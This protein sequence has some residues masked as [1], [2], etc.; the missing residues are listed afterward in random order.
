MAT[1]IL[2]N[3]KEAKKGNP[4]A[5][6]RNA[7]TY[8]MNPEKTENGL[9]VTGN[10]GI[11][12]DEIYNAMMET[13]NVFQKKWGRQ[14]YHF[15]ISFPPGETDE[16]TCFSIGKEFCENY[17]GDRYEYVMAVHNDHEHMH[18]HI[19]FN[20]VGRLDGSKYRYVDGDW[21]KYIQPLTDS[22]AL[23]HGLSKL[24][25]EKGRKK[26]TSYAEHAAEKSGKFT[27][28]KIIRLDIDM[29]VSNSETLE[30]YFSEMKRMGYEIRIG[31]S[32]KY[33]KYVSYHHPAMKEVDGK[34]SKK[35]RRDYNLGEDYTYE[36]I[37]KRIKSRY[38]VHMPRNTVYVDKSLH[39]ITE[40]KS[41]FQVCAVMRYSQA[42]QYHFFDMQ[43]KDQIRVRKDLLRIDS[44]RD[45]CNYILDNNIR[46]APQAQKRLDAVRAQIRKLKENEDDNKYK[47]LFNTPQEAEMAE[48]YRNIYNRL[49]NASSEMP[50][51]EYEK[52]SDELE[53]IENENPGIAA[54]AMSAVT[55]EEAEK[56][57]AVLYE[58][59]RILKGIIKGAD[60]TESVTE[61]E[62][63]NSIDMSYDIKKGV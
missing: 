31:N 42:S 54:E 41:R 53:K 26:G 56:E 25:Y 34:T 12:S 62:P 52:L 49:V 1:T 51:E 19:V 58:E 24:E 16:K 3:L 33:G 8:I 47:R 46:D 17:F 20:S 4:A 32:E 22:L 37:K 57:L 23:K 55:D 60:V 36:D 7:I 21:E 39:E 30:E 2:K 38:K 6:L 13:K 9:W 45:E 28:K 29:A 35:A 14:G 27:W 11:T 18:C 43:L 63:F 40:H 10:C 50:D 5:H 59:K 15:V 44:L 48:R 61:A